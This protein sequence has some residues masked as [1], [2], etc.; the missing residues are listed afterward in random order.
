MNSPRLD[1]TT[2]LP[3]GFW[4][5]G[6]GLGRPAPSGAQPDYGLY[7]GTSRLRARHD[8]T[9]TWPHRWVEWPDFLLPRDRKDAVQ[10]IYDLYERARAGE[11]V[12]VACHGGVGRTGTVMA[13]LAVLAGLSPE[14]AITWTRS[15]YQPKAI[16]TP[17]QRRW[18]LR[19]PSP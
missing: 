10:G 3:S 4:V 11:R 14:E 17:W 12:E 8:H 7:L 5:R 6:R 15:T 16:E 13:C 9:L 19:F 2:Q 1:D 18:V